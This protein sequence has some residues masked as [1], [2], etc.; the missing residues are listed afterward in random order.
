MSD[1]NI[2]KNMMEF[3][4]TEERELLVTSMTTRESQSKNS[5]VMK[6]L[7]KLESEINNEDTKN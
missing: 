5:I 1:E 2:V 6:I 4:E 3:I 7:N